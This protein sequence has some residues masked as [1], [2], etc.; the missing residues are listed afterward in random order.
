MVTLHC[1][2]ERVVVA[3]MMMVDCSD[4][5]TAAD[6]SM[7]LRFQRAQQH[8]TRYRYFLGFC[9][10]CASSREPA[11]AG[12]E[13][14]PEPAPEKTKKQAQVNI[15]SKCFY[16]FNV[17]AAAACDQ[18]EIHS[19]QRWRRAR[20]G[21]SAPPSALARAGFLRR[22]ARPPARASPRCR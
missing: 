5:V 13:P 3:L 20:T 8:K 12:A 14:D 15:N 22:P 16:V 6:L 18:L 1:D 21:F 4:S 9:A 11:M 7:D 19:C 2:N 10:R 17:R